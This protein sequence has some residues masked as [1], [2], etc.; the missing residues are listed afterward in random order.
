MIYENFENC[1]SFSEKREVI[2]EEYIENK[3]EIITAYIIKDGEPYLASATDRIVKH[4]DNAI[5]PLP[6]QY[7]WNSKYLDLSETTVDKKM[8]GVI[9]VIKQ[10]GH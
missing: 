1:L 10:E 7:V 6:I 8:H 2:A 5:I 3:E 4:F 9:R